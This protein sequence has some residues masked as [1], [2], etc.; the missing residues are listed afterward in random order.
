MNEIVQNSRQMLEEMRQFDLKNQKEQEQ[1]DQD[2][3]L[4]I[5]DALVSQNY[6]QDEMLLK[7]TDKLQTIK[8]ISKDELSFTKSDL[9]TPEKKIK[10]DIQFLEQTDE[11]IK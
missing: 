3:V 11:G 10:L 4:K 1:L 2:T 7:I 8:E 5:R 9:M 6:S